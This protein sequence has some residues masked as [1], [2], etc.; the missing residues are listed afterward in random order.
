[1]D[2]NSTV[3]SKISRCKKT[4]TAPRHDT[5]TRHAPTPRTHKNHTKE[6]RETNRTND[7][8]PSSA[9]K[10]HN[11]P[12]TQQPETPS[13]DRR[14]NTLRRPSRYRRQP[15]HDSLCMQVCDPA[16]TSSWENN[17]VNHVRKQQ[18]DF[19]GQSTEVAH[20]STRTTG[21]T[22]HDHHPPTTNN[23]RAH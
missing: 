8:R 21:R 6:K 9:N 4:G 12:K 1:M 18:I 16:P 3:A 11:P 19:G 22:N 5:T 13:G 15:Q 23:P 7:Q 20:R 14:A 10:T 2:G 17:E